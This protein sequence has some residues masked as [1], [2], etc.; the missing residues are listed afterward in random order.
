M[1]R[2]S[3][4]NTKQWLMKTFCEMTAYWWSNSPT[5]NIMFWKNLLNYSL[6]FSSVEWHNAMVR[7]RSS[8]KRLVRPVKAA[9]NL[10]ASS[11]ARKRFAYHTSRLELGVF[12]VHSR[13][14]TSSRN[15]LAFNSKAASWRR[16]WRNFDGRPLA[17]P[18]KLPRFCSSHVSSEETRRKYAWTEAKSAVCGSGQWDGLAT[19]AR[20]RWTTST[21]VEGKDTSVWQL[22]SGGLSSFAYRTVFLLG[23]P[24]HWYQIDPTWSSH[25][26]RRGVKESWR[27]ILDCASQLRQP[28]PTVETLSPVV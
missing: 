2:S 18:C 9:Q 6:E 24:W 13:M 20:V 7:K 14:R 22:H 28:H 15:E 19:C 8:S 25:R 23:S 17:K 10:R 4:I 27:A 26:Y 16:T 1:V 21:N 12:F 11:S 5:E 3:G